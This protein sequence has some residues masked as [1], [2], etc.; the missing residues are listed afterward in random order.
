MGA[1]G[2]LL[3]R[4]TARIS[5][6]GESTR[7]TRCSARVDATMKVYKRFNRVLVA[8]SLVITSAYL[9]STLVGALNAG[10]QKTAILLILLP[11][12]LAAPY[13]VSRIRVQ[14]WVSA[15]LLLFWL[16]TPFILGYFS[17]V[18]SQLFLFESVIWIF[19]LFMFSSY[20]MSKDARFLFRLKG[21]PLKPFL[22]YIAGALIAYFLSYKTGIE[23]SYV[24]IICVFPM[25]LSL[26]IFLT[27]E[28]LEDAERY[29]WAVLISASLLGVLFLFGPKTLS[30][31]SVSEY[32]AGTG[33]ASLQ[34]AVPYLGA[35]TINP[36]SAGDKFSFIF[37]LAYAFWL[38]HRSSKARIA[39]AMICLISGAAM[40]YAQGRAGILAAVISSVI[41]TLL[42]VKAKEPF[43]LTALL[44]FGIIT[45]FIVGGS[46][47]LA[48]HSELLSYA[49][50]IIFLT[51]NPL[52]DPS[53]MGRFD[54][55]VRGWKAI[56]QNPLGIGLFGFGSAGGESWAVHNLWLYLLLSFGVIGFA[57][58]VWIIATFL[59]AFWKGTKSADRGVR[60]LCLMGIGLIINLAVAGQFSPIVWEPYTV[61]IVWIPLATIYAAAV[62]GQRR[63]G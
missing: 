11:F 20:S 14:T 3:G 24:R 29:L 23:L 45:I 30:F 51:S 58:F 55:W 42:S 36:A 52:S 5:I 17:S 57:G 4:P 1:E 44:K 38:F 37:T 50:R 49:E 43:L 53:F 46:W 28:S 39:A 9:G 16:P 40:I 34:M 10:K 56:I 54:L 31:V 63:P 61:G 27:L 13:F 41:I 15:L 6:T 26:T 21:F 18:F 48:V 35:I 59:R 19:L 2:R 22:L 47:Y 7:K 25:L 32:A 62:F 8:V 33:R 60:R 12:A